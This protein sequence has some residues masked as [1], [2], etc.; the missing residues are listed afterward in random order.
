MRHVHIH[1]P[2]ATSKTIFAQV[3]PDCKK[4][5]RMLAFF[6][7]WYGDNCTCLRCGR[8]WADGEWLHLEFARGV[9]ARN[10]ENAKRKWRVMPPVSANH[11]GFDV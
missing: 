4:R 11:F 2:R 7:P 10:I 9:R 6:T 8:E 1:A 5:T 3:C